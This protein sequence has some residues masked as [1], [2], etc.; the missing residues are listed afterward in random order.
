MCVYDVNHNVSGKCIYINRVFV[1]KSQPNTNAV[2]VK[3]NIQINAER[4]IVIYLVYKKCTKEPKWNCFRRFGRITNYAPSG[5][6][7]RF[8]CCTRTRILPAER[9]EQRTSVM[10]EHSAHTH[11]TDRHAS[12]HPANCQGAC[13]AVA[14]ITESFARNCIDVHTHTFLHSRTCEVDRVNACRVG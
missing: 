9:N 7:R 8:G 14:V 1:P 3:I 10:H 12:L 6:K 5:M 4:D 11:E 13:G 2:V